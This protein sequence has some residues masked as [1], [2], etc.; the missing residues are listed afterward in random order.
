MFSR[1]PG[2]ILPLRTIATLVELPTAFA[3]FGF[4][5]ALEVLE[6]SRTA[7]TNQQMQHLHDEL[8]S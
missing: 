4:D 5:G 8:K 6:A 3:W 7:R 2:S 1:D